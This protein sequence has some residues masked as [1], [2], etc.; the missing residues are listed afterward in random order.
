[1]DAGSNGCWL[2]VQSWIDVNIWL[3]PMMSRR[4]KTSKAMASAS[5]FF[6]AS[7][8]P[9]GI[10]A[11]FGGTPARRWRLISGLTGVKA[12]KVSVEPKWPKLPLECAQAPSTNMKPMKHPVHP[13]KPVFKVAPRPRASKWIS[14]ARRR[15]ASARKRAQYLLR[16]EGGTSRRSWIT[17]VA[18]TVGR[19]LR[20]DSNSLVFWQRK[21]HEFV[22]DCLS[23]IPCTYDFNYIWKT[24]CI[25]HTWITYVCMFMLYL[26]DFDGDSQMTLDFLF[27]EHQQN[28]KSNETCM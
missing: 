7:G 15:C 19:D 24:M 18:G 27:E 10:S 8:H 14:A 25:Q 28:N 9:P 16:R 22:T 17:S 2:L 12:G 3:Y 26:I 5:A 4:V 6:N 23:A 21:Q 1:M 11:P 13:L 20:W